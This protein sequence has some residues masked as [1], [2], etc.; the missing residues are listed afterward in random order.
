M[1]LVTDNRVFNAP[2]SRSLCSLARTTHSTHLL[3][4][5][6]LHYHR[7]LILFTPPKIAEIFD[8]VYAVTLF[9]LL[10]RFIKT[11]YNLVMSGNTPISWS[12]WRFRFLEYIGGFPG[13]VS[14]GHHI[15]LSFPP[16]LFFF[17][18]FSVP[19]NISIFRLVSFPPIA[20]LSGFNLL[21]VSWS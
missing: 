19:P 4:I 12:S 20:F 13:F 18:F 3:C 1:F 9:T 2:H 10:T 6:L 8:C 11:I 21:P 5:A 17:F 16:I 14:T 7:S 15:S